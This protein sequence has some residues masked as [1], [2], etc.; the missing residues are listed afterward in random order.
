M[1][2]W[3]RE[4]HGERKYLEGAFRGAYPA[5]ILSD[6]HVKVVLETDE[7]GRK[8]TLGNAGLGVLKALGAGRWLWE[9]SEAEM[10]SAEAVLEKAGLIIHD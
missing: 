9:L 6:E 3:L 10:T 4:M 7:E 8:I 5:S 1:T 2:A